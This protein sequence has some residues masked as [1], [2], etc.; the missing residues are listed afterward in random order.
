MPTPPPEVVTAVLSG[1]TTVTRRCEIYEE[2]GI[3]LWNGTPR[4]RGDTGAVT[5]DS[6]RDERRNMDITL[7]NSDGAIIHGPGNLWYDKV[8]KIY[9][10]I[11]Y[12]AAETQPYIAIL[13]PAS[14]GIM[15]KFLI[16]LGF[17]NLEVFSNAGINDIISFDIVAASDSG[18]ADLTVG[19]AATLLA[20]WNAGIG[21]FT[22][23]PFATASTVPLIATLTTLG[24][25]TAGQWNIN[26]PSY[27]SPFAKFSNYTSNKAGTTYTFPATFAGNVFEAAHGSFVSN[28]V[29]HAGSTA[30][31]KTN[32]NGAR[33]F[34]YHAPLVDT[35]GATALVLW[36]AWHFARSVLLTSAL[37][38]I[39]PIAAEQMWETQ[40]GEFMIDKIDTP[41]TPRIVHLTGRDYTKKLIDSDFDNAISF[42]PGQLI[43]NLV[44]DIASNAGITKFNLSAQGAQTTS[45]NTFD[46][47]SSRWAALSAMCTAANIEIF[48]DKTG[49]LITRPFLDP[50]LSP[51]TLTLL[52]GED[53]G[54]LVDWTLSS[55]DSELYNRVVVSG[56]SDDSSISGAIY[57]GIAE[58]HEPSSPTS[59][60]NLGRT[61]TYYYSSSFFT[62]NDQ[63]AALAVSL[64]KIHAL[65]SFELD[66]TSIV[67]AWLEAG[68]IILVP[69]LPGA[70]ATDP[71]RFLSVS[72]SIPLTLDPMTGVSKRI[73][74]VGDTI[75]TSSGSTGSTPTPPPVVTPPVTIPPDPP[76]IGTITAGA[77]SITVPFTPA[78]TGTAAVSF[79]ATASTG[80]TATGTS[81]PITILV[82][83][84]IAVTASVQ[85]VS[86]VNVLSAA[87]AN[88]N[89]VTPTT[90][91]VAP[92]APT[93]GTISVVN[94]STVSVPFTPSGSGG[95]ATSFTAIMSTGQHVVGTVSPIV[96]TGLTPG[97]AVTATVTA[98]N[99]AGTSAASSVSNSVTPPAII[100]TTTLPFS[101]G[102]HITDQDGGTHDQSLVP[103]Y[104]A[105]LGHPIQIVSVF[106]SRY[107]YQ[108]ITQPNYALDPSTAAG[109][110]S[111]ISYEILLDSWSTVGESYASAS[112]AN[113]KTSTG[114]T[115]AQR[116]TAFGANCVAHGQAN[117]VIRLCSEVNNGSGGN[118]N[119][120]FPTSLVSDFIGAF[121]VAS[122][123]LKAVPGN[124]FTILYD[125]SFDP[126]DPHDLLDAYPG[127][128][129]VD[130][131]GLDCY[132]SV[133]PYGGTW[134]NEADQWDR[135]YNGYGGGMGFKHYVDF[136]NA[137]GKGWCIPEFG[138]GWF[139]GNQPQGGVQ[140]PADSNVT[141][142]KNMFAVASDPGT[143]CLFISFWEDHDLGL[144]ASSVP[145]PNSAAAYRSTF[146]SLVGSPF[147][148]AA[149]TI[150]G[151]PNIGVATAGPGRAT[152]TATPGAGGIPTSY[153]ATSSPGGHTGTS[154]GSPITVS[155]LT[156]GTAYTFTVTATNSAGTSGASAA[157]NS[158]TPTTPPTTFGVTTV[159]TTPDVSVN[160]Q[161][162]RFGCVATAPTTATIAGIWVYVG[163]PSAAGIFTM[164]IYNASG[165]S[166]IGT[167]V[168][169][170]DQI[171]MTAGQ[172]DGWVFCPIH[173]GGA[174]VAGNEYE[175]GIFISPASP[176]N[177]LRFY[178]DATTG[179]NNYI[180]D[181]TGTFPVPA[182][183]WNTGNGAG[184]ETA[185]YSAYAT[186]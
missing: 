23:S 107:S 155:G 91:P 161:G 126:G 179:T 28:A 125:I 34:H 29:T 112:N 185:N 165:P 76:T 12:T 168:G 119:I 173:T 174:V 4:L 92:N 43:D 140:T 10:G 169:Y 106:G 109:M 56:T 150:P 53:G 51:V 17:T 22:A 60:E 9:R 1:Q 181:T 139:Y 42:P 73:T 13:D 59:I 50:T 70:A 164:V 97:T 75:T 2:D 110:T 30:I 116:A 138:L 158:V 47:S 32:S 99:N 114:E 100:S 83:A 38:W 39:F 89:S 64:L 95:A 163:S 57:Q 71:T 16:G 180:Q 25:Q 156:S 8:I 108:T 151:T 102:V 94:N 54:N 162:Y 144:Y 41:R 123:A 104:E 93:I 45:T 86:A 186:Y 178:Y 115:W 167:E 26:A 133:V 141:F 113:G 149:A 81:S 166:T 55:D 183:S 84:G 182:A 171:T 157:S 143:N 46:A 7:D 127:D 87:S 136:C 77:G 175:I 177:G 118:P 65:E 27:D 103:G 146:G 24:T 33:W 11:K 15:Q 6:T 154:I 37:N 135:R 170:C 52:T 78:T 120:Y 131:M 80:Q 129:Y 159:G 35:Q 67:F 63:C 36:N 20:A 122:T 74:I 31:Y 69:A 160:N 152:V 147:P 145:V 85:A 124:N 184:T 48:F 96:V 5:V 3:T 117:A 18:T 62:S 176:S 82:P 72:F 105:W 90:A 134:D 44:Q 68:E 14:N 121:R 137:H 128:A 88:S 49:Y 132:N 111:A 40:I 79:I 153:T 21:V 101:L 66:Y 148:K 142:I 58:N 98:S 172:A 61:K 130:A 19:T